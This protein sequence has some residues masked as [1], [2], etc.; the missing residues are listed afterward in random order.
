M[1][2]RKFG[3]CHPSVRKPHVKLRGLTIDFLLKRSGNAV[4]SAAAPVVADHLGQPAEI[5]IEAGSVQSH[6]AVLSHELAATSREPL[7]IF[8]IS[9]DTLATRCWLKFRIVAS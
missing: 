4:S 3:K 5:R 7:K 2:H 6:V 8:G 1:Q 9:C